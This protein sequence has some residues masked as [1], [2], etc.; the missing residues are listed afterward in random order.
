MLVLLSDGSANGLLNGFCSRFAAPSYDSSA[1]A[2]TGLWE[3]F[4]PDPD[5]L[6]HLKDE[7]ALQCATD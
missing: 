4:I 7:D 5:S 6:R 2:L 3:A 1:P